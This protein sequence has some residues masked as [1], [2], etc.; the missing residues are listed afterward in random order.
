MNQERKGLAEQLKANPLFVELLDGLESSAV[1]RMYSAKTEQDRITAQAA[2]HAARD[3]RAD[4]QR[5]LTN[6]RP[7][8]TVP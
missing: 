6:N 3:F 4:W 1:E 5:L 2:A 7:K 8:K